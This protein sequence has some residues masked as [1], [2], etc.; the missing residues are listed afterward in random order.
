MAIRLKYDPVG[1]PLIASYATGVGQANERRR[2]YAQSLAARAFEE[3]QR[4]QRFNQN[5]LDD[6]ALANLNHKNRLAE[7]AA[8]RGETGTIPAFPLPSYTG[9]PADPGGPIPLLPPDT[10]PA[11]SA[12]ADTGPIPLLP[13]GTSSFVPSLGTAPETKIRI[14]E[15]YAKE[16]ESRGRRI[17]K[18]NKAIGEF[19]TGDSYDR[20]DPIAV[21]RYNEWK[22]ELGRLINELTPEETKI[23]E[24]DKRQR[25]EDFRQTQKDNMALQ[26]Q[27][28]ELHTVNG[29]PQKGAV[30]KARELYP[31]SDY[32]EHVVVTTGHPTRESFGTPAPKISSP[33]TPF[34][35]P[36]QMP[37]TSKPKSTPVNYQDTGGNYSMPQ[38]GSM[39]QELL[40]AIVEKYKNAN[41]LADITDPEDKQLLMY[42]L[43][44]M[45]IS[46]EQLVQML[47]GK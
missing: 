2:K 37:A 17:D 35:D 12:P 8:R 4:W 19:E 23:A 25:I 10:A 42:A 38:Y 28:I 5:R 43:Q 46:E 18:L 13:S 16:D 15:T 3:N 21:D 45:G 26:K 32:P 47:G 14:P 36:G 9:R 40:G 29:V 30:D 33:E 31:I 22:R 27:Y 20:S 44:S 1:A 24:E 11:T 41:S 34:F 7:I 39:E 6:I